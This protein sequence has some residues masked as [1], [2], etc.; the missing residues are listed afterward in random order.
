MEGADNLAS[1]KF[2]VLKSVF[3]NI[4]GAGAPPGPP[5]CL[6]FEFVFETCAAISAHSLHR[7]LF[8]GRADRATTALLDLLDCGWVQL[9]ITAFDGGARCV[10]SL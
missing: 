6:G 7:T 2:K 9:L 3:A 5:P 4:V 1:G 8:G 10:R